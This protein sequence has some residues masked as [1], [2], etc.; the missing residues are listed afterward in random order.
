[1]TAAWTAS[2]TSG[3][4][5]TTD[6]PASRKPSEGVDLGLESAVVFGSGN[7]FADLCLPNPATELRLADAWTAGLPKAIAIA[8]AVLVSVAIES[9]GEHDPQL[10][11]AL[12][13]A[14][15]AIMG[16]V[17][18][19]QTTPAITEVLRLPNFRCSGIAHVYRR[20]GHPIEEKSEQEQAFV[21]FRF[22][23][24]ALRHG[25]KWFAE[26]CVDMDD[27][28]AKVNAKRAGEA[29]G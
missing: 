17:L 19:D 21:L 15:A 22:L 7:V 4:V 2:P 28:R 5:T 3:A 25:P 27:A 14:I 9:V 13:G 24:L 29:R 16:A 11:T 6:N 20:A 8:L 12:D 23:G 10:V 26:A 18:P 1:M